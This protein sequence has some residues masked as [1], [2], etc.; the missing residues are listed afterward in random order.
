MCGGTLRVIA[1][2]ETPEVINKVLT[3]LAARNTSC[4]DHPP[5]PPLHAPQ[6]HPPASPSLILS[7]L[8]TR[9]RHNGAALCLLRPSAPA[10]LTCLC[11]C[12]LQIA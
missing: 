11:D 4:I 2:I 6:A 1:C 9:V 7:W 3:H 10:F 5:A 8:R 12:R